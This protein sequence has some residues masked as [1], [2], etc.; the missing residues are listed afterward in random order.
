MAWATLDPSPAAGWP[1]SPTPNLWVRALDRLRLWISVGERE[2]GWDGWT[3]GDGSPASG[4]GG[5][6]PGRVNPAARAKNN[7]SW[8]VLVSW[9]SSMMTCWKIWPAWGGGSATDAGRVA[10]TATGR[11]SD[12]QPAAGGSSD[13]ECRRRSS[14][15]RRHK[16]CT[17]APWT[18]SIGLPNNAPASRPRTAQRPRPRPRPQPRGAAPAP[19]GEPTRPRFVRRVASDCSSCPESC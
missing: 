8:M 18:S 17:G 7:R 3:G 1:A 5:R 2:F 10:A 16:E 14:S 11:W 13:T 4:L 15:R 6:V 12:W 9:Y 19:P